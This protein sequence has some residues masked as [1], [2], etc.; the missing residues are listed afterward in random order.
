MGALLQCERCWSGEK[1]VPCHALP[2]AG[3]VML[4]ETYTSC[5]KP[6][7]VYEGKPI[8]PSNV[9]ELQRGGTG[10]SHP[11]LGPTSPILI[12]PFAW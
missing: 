5:I 9:I 8:K 2:C 3:D 12:S 4:H 7:G 6:D 10:L 1:E 11:N